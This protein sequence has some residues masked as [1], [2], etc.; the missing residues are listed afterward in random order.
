MLPNFKQ[1]GLLLDTFSTAAINS[2]LPGAPRLCL[3]PKRLPLG[4]G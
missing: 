4:K 3:S 1:I 2:I